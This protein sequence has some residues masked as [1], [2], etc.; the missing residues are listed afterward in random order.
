MVMLSILNCSHFRNP[1]S[2]MTMMILQ[3]SFAFS[4]YRDQHFFAVSL[5][6]SF[7]TRPLQHVRSSQTQHAPESRL[8]GSSARSFHSQLTPLIFLFAFCSPHQK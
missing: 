6:A 7:A 3:L 2:M 5:D 4:A 8:A 1:T